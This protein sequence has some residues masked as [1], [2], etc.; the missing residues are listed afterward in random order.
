MFNMASHLI[1]HPS[2]SVPPGACSNETHATTAA[3]LT[4]CAEKNGTQKP[5]QTAFLLLVHPSPSGSQSTNVLSIIYHNNAHDHL[6]YH[7]NQW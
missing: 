1:L 4:I 5:D 6:S 2:V 3:L 7:I